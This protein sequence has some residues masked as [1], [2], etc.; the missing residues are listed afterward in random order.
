MKLDSSHR[1]IP[2]ASR[3]KILVTLQGE[4]VAP[5]FDTCREVLIAVEGQGSTRHD[6]ETVVLPGESAED[7]CSLI[8][9]EQID[10]VI[11]G[12]IEEEYFQFL[13][14]KRV[15]VVDFVV[16][17]WSRALDSAA[18]GTLKS[19]DVLIPR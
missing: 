12:G 19:G 17:P 18:D 4:D 5:R 16:G 6:L 7:L 2:E 13:V 10:T 15:N 8:L 14:W 3:R 1:R 11:C 9:R